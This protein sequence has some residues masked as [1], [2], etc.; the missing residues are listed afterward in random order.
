MP[1]KLTTHA[2]EQK[3]Y[4][5][6]WTFTD[7]DGNSVVPTAV[8]WTLTDTDGATVNARSGVSATAATTVTIVL[9]GTDLSMISGKS[10]E[11]LLLIEWT[12]NSSY[13][14]GLQDAEQATF[15]IDDLAAVSG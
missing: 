8:T 5:T 9:T 14:S 2:N 4:T 13:G 3:S 15:I 10:N 1:V 12:Y 11:R 6:Q 7:E